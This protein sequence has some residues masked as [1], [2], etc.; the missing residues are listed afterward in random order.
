MRGT[1]WFRLRLVI[2]AGAAVLVLFVL[3]ERYEQCRTLPPEI[4][5]FLAVFAVAGLAF[6]PPRGRHPGREPIERPGVVQAIAPCE[7]VLPG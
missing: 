3:A 7:S 4:L 2:I 1:T 6:T 5:I